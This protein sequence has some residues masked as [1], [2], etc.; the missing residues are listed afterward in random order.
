MDPTKVSEMVR[1]L[2][3]K[4]QRELANRVEKEVQKFSAGKPTTMFASHSYDPTKT[5]P[6][7]DATLEVQQFNYNRLEQEF[8]DLY[9]VA[10]EFPA[11]EE[12]QRMKDLATGMSSLKS[13]FPEIQTN[14]LEAIIA[15]INGKEGSTASLNARLGI[16]RGGRRKNKSSRKPSRKG[17]KN[18][19]KT[20][21]N[22]RKGTKKH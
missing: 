18:Q 13:M 11:P 10:G 20:K 8:L 21:K 14:Y 22:K 4:E 2:Q 3:E 6:V 15:V 17:T 1:I 9:S 7:T 5:L 16:V 19:K 12:M